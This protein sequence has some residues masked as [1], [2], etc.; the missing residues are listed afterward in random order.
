MRSRSLY[1]TESPRPVDQGYWELEMDAVR[2]SQAALL[3]A[4]NT[5]TLRLLLRDS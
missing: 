2:P 5:D 4:S 3:L 1:F